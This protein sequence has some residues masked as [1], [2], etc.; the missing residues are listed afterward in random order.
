MRAAALD[1]FGGVENLHVKQLPVPEPGPDEVLLRV[2]S[3]GVGVWDPF[4]REGEFA[5]IKRR[6]MSV[7]S[8]G[9]NLIDALHHIAGRVDIGGLGGRLFGN[10]PALIAR[11][12]QGVH[13]GRPI[14]FTLEQFRVLTART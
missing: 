3:A 12:V 10:C 4:E 5:K 11:A 2:E 6:R 7:P 9:E 8:G 1:R 13:D 14:C